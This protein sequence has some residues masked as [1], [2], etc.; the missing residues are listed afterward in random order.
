VTIAE[1]SM[2]LEGWKPA[3]VV[4]DC[5]GLLVDTE[6]CWTIAERQVFARRGLGFGPEQKAL[7]PW[8]T[9]DW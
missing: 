9:N 2:A 3:A 6:T 7:V 4:F 8:M 1:R 5:D